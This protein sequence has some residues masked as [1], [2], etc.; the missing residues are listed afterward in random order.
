MVDKTFR[1]E[2]VIQKI[3]KSMS[4][5]GLKAG[6]RLPSVRKLSAELSVSINTV[7]Q[8]YAILEA[9]GIIFSKP[10]SGY[11]IHT[12]TAHKLSNPID[13]NY[14]PLPSTVEVSSMA[15]A[16]MKNAL[17][18]GIINFSILAPINELLPITK[19]NKA[20]QASLKEHSNESYQYPLVEGHPR[21][22]KQIVRRTLNWN[23]HI[24]QDK[25]LVT[26]GCM[27][28]INLC[29]DSLTKPG[30]IIAVESPTY[31]GIL[32]SLE[33]RGLKALEIATDSITG[34]V[35]ADLTRA[36]DTNMVTACIFMP[37]CHH[38]L[39]AMMPEDNKIKLVQL[40][41]ERGIPLIED[42]SL[43]EL[44]FSAHRP[45]PAKAYDTTDNVLYCSS[46]SKSLAPGFRV[47]WVSAGKYHAQLLKL[48]FGSNIATTGLLQDAIGR[49]LETGQYES[50]LKKMRHAMQSQIIRYAAAIDQYFPEN[51][52]IS[53]PNGG[54]SLWIELPEEVDALQLQR[55]AITAGIGICPGHI[56]STLTIYHHY[57]RI[58]CCPLWNIKIENS[59]QS[60]GRLS[61]KMI[62]SNKQRSNTVK[63]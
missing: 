14:I 59:I 41:A 42:D 8:A 30:D 24:S 1:Y 23:Q 35:L 11:Y 47:G 7:F 26:N 56:F 37:A 38:P 17:E 46:F 27:E 32:Q 39:G 43:G 2:E 36:L 16:M 44:Y 12:T 48:K 25:I 9:R 57:I 20:V 28:A 58:N 13:E 6:D 50:H 40:L 21:L 55:N 31:H 5:L 3:E 61:Q 33:A 63:K 10:K 60:L 22:L 45:L 18:Y 54:L 52:R 62:D 29:L 53:T 34:L 4:N 51:T 15:T 19:L 49:Y